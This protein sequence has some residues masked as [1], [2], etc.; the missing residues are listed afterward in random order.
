MGKV[1]DAMFAF[2]FD[3]A[4][5]PS[6]PVTILG[7]RTASLH[8]KSEANC[9][10]LRDAKVPT[11]HDSPRAAVPFL[12]RGQGITGSSLHAFIVSEP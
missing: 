10:N 1:I 9:K 2:I 7:R 5:A 6:V 4:R 11:M 12:V 3:P 8:R